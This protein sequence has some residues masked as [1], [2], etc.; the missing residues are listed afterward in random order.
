MADRA[1]GHPKTLRATQR[2]VF[3]NRGDGVGDRLGY[4]AAAGIVRTEH[5]RRV[6]V[7]RVVERDRETPRTS[8]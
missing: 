6:D 8:A 3:A 1:F 7:G 4:R 2:H 5:L